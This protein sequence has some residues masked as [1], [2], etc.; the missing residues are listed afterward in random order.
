MKAICFG[1]YLLRLNPPM[2]KRFVQASKF[3]CAFTG[4]EAN[5]A[6]S[7]SNFWIKTEFVTKVPAHE[8]GQ[9]SLNY[10]K[11]Y[12]VGV[13][14]VIRGGDRIGLFY[15]ETGASQRGGKVIYD[16]KNSAFTEAKRS[17][18]DWDKIFEGA[19]WFHFTG[20]LHCRMR[21]SK[22]VLTH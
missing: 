16:R 7:L 3:L 10:I 5:V 21:C 18:F 14:N 2:S 13:N 8:I 19:T 22:F 12:G 17:E 20:I 15:L 4:A 9:A 1:D 6:V 11:Q